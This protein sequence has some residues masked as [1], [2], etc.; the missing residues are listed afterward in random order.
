MGVEPVL[1]VALA[2][3]SFPRGMG[4]YDVSVLEAALNKQHCTLAWFDARRGTEGGIHS[5]TANGSYFL[6]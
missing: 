5:C 6:S 4:Y 1:T 3:I 2:L